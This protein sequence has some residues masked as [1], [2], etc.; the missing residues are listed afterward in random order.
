M[1]ELCEITNK[2][3]GGA[4]S[5]I[6]W[7]YLLIFNN[8]KSKSPPRTVKLCILQSSLEA[9]LLDLHSYAGQQL[10][11]R[12]AL[13]KVTADLPVITS[14]GVFSVLDP[15][16][17][18]ASCEADDQPGHSGHTLLWL[19]LPHGE[20]Q[21]ILETLISSSVA[22]PLLGFGIWGKSLK[23]FEFP[24]PVFGGGGGGA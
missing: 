3:G 7:F 12:E 14:K 17:L 21:L 6:K 4:V 1:V 23:L 10:E 5:N 22:L 20:D 2:K 19:L 9:I 18:F 13:S 24:F 11:L 15:S 16:R 8:K